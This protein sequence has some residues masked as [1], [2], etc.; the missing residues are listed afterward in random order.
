[1]IWGLSE[2]LLKL[3]SRNWSLQRKLHLLLG[4][5]GPG[6][7]C[8]APPPSPVSPRGPGCSRH[9]PALG[10]PRQGES[11]SAGR[12]P[13]CAFQISGARAPPEELPARLPQARGL[14]PQTRRGGEV[15][16]RDRSRGS[17]RFALARARPHD[18]THK[19]F[20]VARSRA[21]HVTRP[22]RPARQLSL[23]HQGTA[24]RFSRDAR[25]G[26]SLPAPLPG[27]PGLSPTHPD[28]LNG[29]CGDVRHLRTPESRR[30]SVGRQG[31][32]AEGPR[33]LR[34]PVPRRGPPTRVSAAT[35][36]TPALA[37]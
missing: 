8:P 7:L 3:F 2:Q 18:G 10:G 4:R 23:P 21:R 9:Q 37:Q 25:S 36:T 16:G 17:S 11:F 12:R 27:P 31:A 30:N 14:L 35:S 34:E 28:L 32:R 20:Q 22:R 6:L 29:V 33:E 24:G 13:T 1:M 26:A 5:G 19:A 15:P